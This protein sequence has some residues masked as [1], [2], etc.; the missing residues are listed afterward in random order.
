MTDDETKRLI[1]GVLLPRE[2]IRL[3][4]PPERDSQEFFNMGV[5]YVLN[6]PTNLS[7]DY[8]ERLLI[9]IARD[10]EVHPEWL[11]ELPEPEQSQLTSMLRSVQR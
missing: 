9:S 1:E 3:P 5:R 8:I 10:A 7:K 6:P 2:I 11:N 4:P